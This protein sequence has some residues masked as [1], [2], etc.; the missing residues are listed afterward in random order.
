MKGEL[1]QFQS[2]D[3]IV[4]YRN[5][6]ITKQ[7]IEFIDSILAQYPPQTTKRTLIAE[8]ICMV[9]NWRQANGSLSL[10]ACMDLLRRLAEWGHIQFPADKRGSKMSK[11]IFPILTPDLIALPW[12]EV[13]DEDADLDSVIVRP[14]T[15]EERMGWRLFMGRYHYLGCRPIVG[16]HLLYAAFLGNCANELV[17]LIGWASAA[18]RSPLRERY[19]GWDEKQ[20][21]NHLHLVVNNIRF[22]VPN[23]IRVRNLAS[24]VLSLNLK[25]LSAD[26]QQAWG[27]PVLLAETFVDNAYHGTCYKAANWTYLGQTA[28][29][30]KRGNAYLFDSTSKA[31][32]VYPLRHNACHLL[33]HAK[34]KE[35]LQ[36]DSTTRSRS[37]RSDDPSIR[38]EIDECRSTQGPGTSGTDSF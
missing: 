38:S 21:S 4:R 17:A 14:I 27:H 34:T 33:R 13:R 15:R 11:K 19:I 20:K 16:E 6:N 29:R 35:E 32:Y 18:L 2:P 31:L 36:R 37:G 25:R 22:L 1:L 23:W 26:W 8:T 24:K 5:R 3:I 28:G 30:R 7:D 12:A 9:W 10:I